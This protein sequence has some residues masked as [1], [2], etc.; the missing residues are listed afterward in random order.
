MLIL[1]RYCSSTLCTVL[2]CLIILPP[3]SQVPLLS[4]NAGGNP[5]DFVSSPQLLQ[6]S[7][8][9][10][11]VIGEHE[12]TLWYRKLL[13]YL[14]LTFEYIEPPRH[15]ITKVLSSIMVFSSL[16]IVFNYCFSEPVLK[17]QYLTKLKR[18]LPS[19]LDGLEDD[20]MKRAFDEVSTKI[21]I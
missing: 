9:Q 19:Y 17:S 4:P 18:I 20:D 5:W 1:C 16:S 15:N 3:C 13:Y 2:T 8:Q 10:Q 12:K 7:Q 11:T 14:I 6:S 21:K